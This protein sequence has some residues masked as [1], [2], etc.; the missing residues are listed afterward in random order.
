MTSLLQNAALEAIFFSKETVDEKLLL[1]VAKKRDIN[2][3]RS[4]FE[5]SNIETLENENAAEKGKRGVY[6]TYVHGPFPPVRKI[7]GRPRTQRDKNDIVLLYNDCDKLGLS[8]TQKLYEAGLCYEST[9]QI[10]KH[11]FAKKENES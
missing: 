9:E 3:A 4:N 1:S 10:V 2:A 11:H 8:L 6:Q 5:V 7:R